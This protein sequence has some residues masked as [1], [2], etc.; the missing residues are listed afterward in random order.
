MCVGVEISLFLAYVIQRDT[1][2]TA[3]NCLQLITSWNGHFLTRGEGERR[4]G[5][6]GEEGG[7]KG[8]R[9]Q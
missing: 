1:E 6:G 4:E 7:R 3:L 5:G 2:R 8:C 9:L